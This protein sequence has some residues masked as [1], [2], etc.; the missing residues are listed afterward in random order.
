MKWIIESLLLPPVGLYLLVAIGVMLRAATSRV[1]LRRAGTALA[2]VGA[3][4]LVALSIPYVAYVLLAGLQTAPAIPPDAA[5]IEADAILVLSADV[6]CDPPEYGSDQ[7][8]PLSL[9]RCR[10]GATLARRTGLPLV[11]TGGVLRPDRRPV[12]HVLRDFVEEDLGTPVAWT[13]DASLSTRQNA[14]LSAEGLRERGITR[15]AV[16]THA[17]HMPRARAAFERAGLEVL[18]APMAPHSIPHRLGRG[19]MPRGRSL[20]DS[21]WAVHE[22]V[23]RLWYRISG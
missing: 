20:R 22:Y 9:E 23:G 13:E 4:A 3:G 10:Y 1:G 18:P 17:W 5:A 21:C 19:L 14:R 2:G 6:D 11:I 7:P 16:V 12:S 8:G 15:V